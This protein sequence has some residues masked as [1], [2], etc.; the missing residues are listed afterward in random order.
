MRLTK[1]EVHNFKGIA[2]ASFEW[3]RYIVLIGE[4]N[5][6]KSSI[7]QAL[8]WFLSGS[9]IKDDQL[10]YNHNADAA[11]PVELIGH[12]S[13]LSE[14]EKAETAV[15][16]RMLGDKWILKKSFWRDATG[17]WKEQYFSMSASEQF[18]DWPEATASWGAFAEP[19]QPTILAW[20]ERGVR[21]SI[22]K[23][24]ELKA[25]VRQEKPELV[26]L[27]PPDWS[28]NPGGGG[29]WK[30]NA[31]SILPRPIFIHAVHDAASESNSKDASSYGKIISLLVE[32]R[33]MGRP[34]IAALRTKMK[35]VLALFNPDPEHPERQAEE[36]R[37]IQEKINEFLNEVVSGSV[38]IATK[39]P[40]LQPLLLPSTTLIMKAEGAAVET[41]VEHQGHGLQRSLII[42]LLQVLASVQAELDAADPENMSRPTIFMIE[43]PELYL[44]PQMER[45]MRDVLYRV[46]SQDQTQAIC[47]SHSPIFLD[48]GERHKSIVRV[49]K[50]VGNVQCFQVLSDLFDGADA[51][52]QKERLKFLS[53]FHPGVNEVF[54]AKRVI[55]FEGRTEVTAFE[56]AALQTGIF[57][58]HQNARRDVTMIDCGG[59]PN[60][61]LF[62]KVLNHFQIPYLAVYD[63]DQG[64]PQSMLQNPIIDTLAM[65]GHADNRSFRISPADIETLLGYAVG[66]DPKPLRAVTRITHLV[67]GPGLPAQFLAALNQV[68]FGQPVEPHR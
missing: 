14:M 56:F 40:D 6:G 29:N 64:N 59:K 51:A 42:T 20:A 55:L 28:P 52:S 8:N 16:G 5:V 38:R 13:D 7:L 53:E 34:E 63:E 22:A 30:S 46:A 44:H 45:K 48:M 43:E 37:E 54:F 2:N 60:I 39:E 61:P 1:F 65:Q 50:E 9:A 23:L 58:R 62:Q 17:T 36:V 12:F 67:A 10:C 47:C 21:P 57:Q 41:L 24:E 19:Y 68:Y 15:A 31:N 49:V 32:K 4:N 33:M 35:E 27:T 18:A 25:R 11:N 26:T 66:N 3:D